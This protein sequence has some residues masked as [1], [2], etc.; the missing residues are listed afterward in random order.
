MNLVA[1]TQ[2]APNSASAFSNNVSEIQIPISVVR[3]IFTTGGGIL[4]HDLSR[5]DSLDRDWTWL[6]C[7]S[8]LSTNISHITLSMCLV[9]EPFKSLSRNTE[10]FFDSVGGI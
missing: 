4:A 1:I 2:F 5:V 10:G 6:A 7:A 3:A 9:E 8:G